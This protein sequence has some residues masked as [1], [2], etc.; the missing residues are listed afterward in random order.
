M[1][2]C[3]VASNMSDNLSSLKPA[4]DQE[5]E[6][7]PTKAL[8][9]SECPYEVGTTERKKWI[10]CQKAK[11]YRE[12]HPERVH[13]QNV[14]RFHTEE[15]KTYR[16]EWVRKNHDKVLRYAYKYKEDNQDK[17]KE[18]DRFYRPRRNQLSNE[19]KK[20]FGVKRIKVPEVKGL[21]EKPVAIALAQRVNGKREQSVKVGEHSYR[22][23]VVS[24]DRLFEVKRVDY[25]KG[26]VK[27]VLIYAE[28]AKLKPCIHI[29]GMAKLIPATAESFK[30]EIQ[31]ECDKH[32][33]ECSFE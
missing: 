23:D 20:R 26:A 22:A 8:P 4:M 11:R 7:P 33:I 28:A 9:T 18:Y 6:A 27:Q 24:A 21:K 5:A 2:D 13:D 30:Q 10:N 32:G 3:A 14:K 25:W 29:F 1:P 31:Q 16:N 12:K 15:Y 19:H 17:I